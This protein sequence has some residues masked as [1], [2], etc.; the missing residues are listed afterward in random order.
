MDYGKIIRETR[1]KQGMSQKE[2]ARLIG[3]TSRSIIYWENGQRKISLECADK[4]FKALHMN[5][6]IGEEKKQE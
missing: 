2:L 4:I 3:V 6:Q 1:T 5:I